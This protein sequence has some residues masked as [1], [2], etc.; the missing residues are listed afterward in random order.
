MIR[1]NSGATK[2]HRLFR[3][4]SVRLADFFGLRSSHV[5]FAL[6]SPLTILIAPNGYGKTTLLHW[7]YG[8]NC[9]LGASSKTS[10]N[11]TEKA[12]TIAK[13]VTF[14]GFIFSEQK[15]TFDLPKDYAHSS[16][17]TPA[18]SELEFTYQA[19][20]E[21]FH[22]LFALSSDP[23]PVVAVFLFAKAK[24][25]KAT[26]SAHRSLEL[27]EKLFSAVQEYPF[28]SVPFF[29][30]PQVLNAARLSSESFRLTLTNA[31]GESKE[32]LQSDDGTKEILAYF[33][34]FP[35]VLSELK[36]APK[37]DSKHLSTLD[38]FLVLLYLNLFA[39]EHEDLP[40]LRN[41]LAKAEKA[42]AEFL[43]NPLG[44]PLL[45][46]EKALAEFLQASLASLSSALS[47]HEGIYSPEE[48][49]ETITL[50]S[51]VPA[52]L[53]PA[54]LH[55][56]SLL[57]KR[58]PS[59][60]PLGEIPAS[61]DEASLTPIG[62]SSLGGKKGLLDDPVGLMRDL[63]AFYSIKE[64]FDM[65]AKDQ[66]YHLEIDNEGTPFVAKAR[67]GQANPRLCPLPSLS[68]GEK[69]LLVILFQ[70]ITR[71]NEPLVFYLDEPEISL[72]L[73]WQEDLLGALLPHLNPAS[74]LI[75][76]THSPYIA[77][78]YGERIVR[79]VEDK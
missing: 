6:D 8:L 70:L 59:A 51:Y 3:L 45:P 60:I 22:I 31:Y 69:N 66:G 18:F 33:A 55:R 64:A 28:Q 38:K 36:K 29:L 50:L 52:S 24:P 21:S 41:R 12:S 54:S 35:P 25:K 7:C 56:L 53:S 19:E 16:H 78:N 57:L 47:D 65:V 76:A 74:R 4:E 44:D 34:S 79:F 20:G 32:L 46:S 49:E 77:E 39:R 73:E 72:H 75:I 26:F 63:L 61:R 23:R 2:P 42:L 37:A 15:A 43:L 5:N 48:R 11:E 27:A 30:A 67:L 62:E 9:L 71:E 58:D 68:S 40:S 14:Y 1:N 17:A 10:L 13:F